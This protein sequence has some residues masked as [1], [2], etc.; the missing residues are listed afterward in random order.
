MQGQDN[1]CNMTLGYKRLWRMPHTKNNLK[2][3]KGSVGE[4]MTE[5]DMTRAKTVQKVNEQIKRS[6]MALRKQ[7]DQKVCLGTT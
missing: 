2:S 1:C 6:V 7:T 4:M 5:D 3:K